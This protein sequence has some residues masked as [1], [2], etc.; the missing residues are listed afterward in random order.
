MWIDIRGTGIREIPASAY[1]GGKIFADKGQLR[2]ADE[3]VVMTV[4]EATLTQ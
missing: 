3:P 4:N 2:E 1:I